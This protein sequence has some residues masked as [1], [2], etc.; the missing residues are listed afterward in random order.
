MFLVQNHKIVEVGGRPFGAKI[1]VAALLFISFSANII[2]QWAVTV[3]I[4]YIVLRFFFNK[5]T[6]LKELF[7]ITSYSIIP[8]M[9]SSVLSGVV[10]SSQF[11]R[12][13]FTLLRLVTVIMNM[14]CYLYALYLF[15]HSIKPLY[16][17]IMPKERVIASLLAFGG[18]L[19]FFYLPNLLAKS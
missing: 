4:C 12:V 2:I 19:V 7:F 10:L 1:A 18:V 6:D 9:T 13:P 17:H 16:E 5:S 8:I 11:Q 15:Q 3:S 14:G